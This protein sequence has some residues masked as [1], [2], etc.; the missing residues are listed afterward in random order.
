SNII[1]ILQSA[2]SKNAITIG[3]TSQ[4]D[5]PISEGADISFLIPSSNDLVADVCSIHEVSV[6]YLLDIILKEFQRKIQ[7]EVI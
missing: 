2:E 4:R 3:V 1:I 5:S 7:K 6:F